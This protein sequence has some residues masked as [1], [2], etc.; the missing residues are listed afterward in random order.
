MNLIKK[1]HCTGPNSIPDSLAHL[2]AVVALLLIS[3]SLP[4]QTLTPPTMLRSG[5]GHTLALM[6]DGSVRAWGRNVEGQLGLGHTLIQAWPQTVPGLSGVTSIS[7][8]WGHSLAL[9][10]NQ[11]VI[12]WG[13]NNYRQ[14]GIASV[15]HLTTPQLVPGLA[16]VTAISAGADHS[17]ALLSDGSVVSWGRNDAGQLGRGFL[18]PTESTPGTVVSIA[19][20]AEICAGGHFSLARLPNGEVRS[21]GSNNYGQLGINIIGGVAHT[22]GIVQ[23]LSSVASLAA[24]RHHWVA[25]LTDGSLAS[26]GRGDI[27]QLGQGALVTSSP[28]PGII[29][30]SSLGTAVLQVAAGR[31][32]SL[33]LMSDGT[34]KSWGLNDQG[35]LGQGGNTSQS[36]PQSV[37]GLSGVSVL[38]A[39]WEHSLA[40]HTNSSGSSW[41]LNNQYQLGLL[42]TS[43]QTVPQLIT[44]LAC[45]SSPYSMSIGEVG[46]TAVSVTIPCNMETSGRI[47]SPFYQNFFTANPLNATNPGT[48]AWFGLHISLPDVY[49]WFNAGQSGMS[50]AY[51]A[52]DITGGATA[53]LA[54][55]PA[56]LSGITIHGVSIAVDALTFNV[57]AISDVTSHTF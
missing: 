36:L 16:G 4:A 1:Q 18:S 55:P 29:P 54:F 46:T 43:S 40:L 35:Q 20:V 38:S 53:S 2:L 56:V 9:L 41:G 50:L 17:L 21:W 14:L 47:P 23:C 25:L 44:S 15:T 30:S 33:A 24:G 39:G 28:C 12:A 3:A 37:T 19:G 22:P 45:V 10:S 5:Y 52:L 8:G 7:A 31:D 13:N 34:A 6:S 51:G 42:N 57:I 49:L 27:G 48:G 26:C 32:H 11:T